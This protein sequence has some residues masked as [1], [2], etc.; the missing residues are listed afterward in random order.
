[1]GQEPR[2]KGL[3]LRQEAGLA[4]ADMVRSTWIYR[5][6]KR[7]RAGI[8]SSISALKRAFGMD[9]CTWSGWEG[10]QRY[11]W[12]IVVSHNLFTVARI[13]LAQA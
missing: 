10:F 13:R 9:R 4:V 2:G 1:V 11:I 8:E 5:K 6:L 3:L 7:F 12:S